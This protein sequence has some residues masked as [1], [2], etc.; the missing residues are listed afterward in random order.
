MSTPEAS[1]MGLRLLNR[2]YVE[3]PLPAG[4]LCR[5][6]R[7]QDTVLRRSIAVKAV[8][9]E[10]VD[11]YRAALHATAS[12]SHP[13]VVATYDALEQD[14]WLFVI[15]EYVTARP[16]S[17]YLRDGVPSE[18][19]A[20]LAGQIAR[21]IAYAHAHEMTHG[22]LTPA[23]V[24][25]DRQAT[26]RINNFRLPPDE[27]YFMARAHEWQTTP[28]SLLTAGGSPARQDVAAVGLLL[29]LLLSEVKRDTGAGS[30]TPGARRDFRADV[31]EPLRDLVR[32]CVQCDNPSAILDADTL[33]HELEEISGELAK[34]RAKAAEH[35]PPA[36]RVA[37]AAVAQEAA[38][39]AEATLGGMRSWGTVLAG[40]PVS[41]NAPTV[42]QD[43]EAAPW[44]AAVPTAAIAPRLRLP[45]RPMPERGQ[46]AYAPAKYARSATALDEKSDFTTESPAQSGQIRLWVLILIGIAL[47][48]LFFVI[49]YLMPYRLGG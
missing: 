48:V 3:E 18:R 14:E 13:A 46:G 11:D 47:F 22:D 26:V 12:L 41:Q 2:Y 9:P 6:Y 25:V 43:T 34:S 10:R 28:E 24:L 36:L 1:H 16:L 44:L 33:C 19:A 4:A 38:W 23:S 5:V 17:T 42:P 29:W 27:D 31:Q 21:A 35:T 40:D 8:P 20:D 15:Q 49:G 7:G 45:S 39:S 32:R 37:R 30:G